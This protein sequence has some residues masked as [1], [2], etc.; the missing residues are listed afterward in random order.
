MKEQN[1]ASDGSAE[2]TRNLAPQRVIYTIFYPSIARLKIQNA[3]S[4]RNVSR[5]NVLEKQKLD[6]CMVRSN[7]DGVWRISHNMA[8][9]AY[10]NI[11]VSGRDV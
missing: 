11:A 10:R 6:S 4:K 7:D 2:H 9:N 1:R 5:T 8:A 3:P